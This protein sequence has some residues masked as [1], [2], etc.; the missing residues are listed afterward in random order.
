M[1]PDTIVQANEWKFLNTWIA[2]NLD[3]SESIQSQVC[4][5]TTLLKKMGRT[6]MVV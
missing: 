6:P 4:H 2:L 1:E 5:L 3:L